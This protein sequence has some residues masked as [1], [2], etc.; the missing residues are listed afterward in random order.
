MI[1]TVDNDFDIAFMDVKL[2]GKN[3]VESYIEIYKFNP[4]SRVVM[5][6][7]YIVAHLL[8]KVVEKGAWGVLYKTF[9]MKKKSAD[10]GKASVP[11][12]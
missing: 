12:V 10:D 8:G 7:G 6:I 1:L 9:D 4:D 5:I 2:P 3:G 11:V